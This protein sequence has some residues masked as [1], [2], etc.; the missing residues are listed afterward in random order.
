MGG[1]EKGVY[2]IKALEAKVKRWTT[3]YEIRKIL[4]IEPT[5]CTNTVHLVL[6]YPIIKLSFGFPIC[7]LENIDHVCSLPKRL[8]T[9][10]PNFFNMKSFNLC[11]LALNRL[12]LPIS[13]L[14]ALEFWLLL[15][16]QKAEWDYELSPI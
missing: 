3:F 6:D 1:I 16:L 13:M 7:Y 9:Y 8:R 12:M 5:L 4:H 10:V 11:G 15:H 14:N 2:Y